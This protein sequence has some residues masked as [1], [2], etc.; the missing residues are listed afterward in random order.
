VCAAWESQVRAMGG[1]RARALL[2][3]LVFPLLSCIVNGE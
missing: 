1:P 3:L 2:L